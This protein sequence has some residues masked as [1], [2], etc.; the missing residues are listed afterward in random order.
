MPAVITLLLLSVFSPAFWG[1]METTS[2][3]DIQ[4]RNL[5]VQAFRVISG[6]DNRTPLSGV[7]V[8]VYD[9]N[10]ASPAATELTNR[11]GAANINLET[12][13]AG[14]NINVT[15]AYNNQVQSKTSIL[16]CR[17][18]LLVFLFD[19]TV[20]SNI[21]CAN[22]SGRD[23][24][25]FVNEN[26]SRELRQNMP[27]GIRRYER[28][29]SLTNSSQTESITV[30]IPAVNAPYDIEGV[31]IGSSPTGSNPV[32]VPPN[33]TLSIC[34]SA[35]TENAGIFNQSINL[36]LSCEGS[37]GT[38]TLDLS[39]EV[40]EPGCDCE[41]LEEE[42]IVIL[43][44]SVPV[45]GS[46]E[47]TEV[48]FTNTLSCA[49]EISR[50]GF[51]GNDGWTILSPQFPQTLQPGES[52]TIEA[53]FTPVK[54]LENSDTLNLNI[55]PEGTQ[56]NCPFDVIFSGE[57]CSNSCP[58]LAFDVYPLRIFNSPVPYDTLSNRDD[59]R[60][61]VSITDFDPP[62]LSTV[63]KAYTVYNPDSACNEITIDITAIPQDNYAGDY[64]SISPQR[65]TLAPGDSSAVNVIFTAPSYQELQQIAAAR[66]NTGQTS[67]SAFTIRLRLQ[68]GSCL[69]EV[70]ISSVV[71]I[72]PEISP[73]INLRAYSQRTPLKPEPEKEIYYLGDDARTINRGI[74][75][76]WGEY[77]PVNGDIY[78]DV[79]DTLASA[80]PP[81]EPILK[82]IDP[83]IEMKLWRTQVPEA[84]FSNVSAIVTEFSN[85]PGHSTGYSQNPITNLNVGDIIAFKI[86]AFT[87][88]L[89][90]IRRVDNGTE[91]T[92][93]R[94]SG[95]E[96]RTIYPI[97]IPF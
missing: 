41:E 89:M 23:S 28:C 1:C 44:E 26:G 11:N 68:A 42:Y 24:L 12:P 27:E 8:N 15:A 86:N 17:D 7:E 75:G 62:F 77:P 83:N 67:D 20:V 55:Q 40:V 59:N 82:L 74:N 43:P 72:F 78:I 90:Y 56:N 29:W 30:S 88:G 58:Y 6:G 35:G 34:F 18:T 93:S 79:N 19:T 51:D 37:Q 16:I 54:A 33:T 73:I 76:T 5:V 52:L 3:E 95:I 84:D 53:R 13:L 46:E 14:R 97:Y 70:N 81:Q 22:L 31:Y 49:V 60:V 25:I 61:F 47:H 65:I 39:A 57:G 64:Y 96:F 94:Q 48:V 80:Q 9:I 92:S 32:T 2:P 10:E 38:Y 85:D 36:G 4:V 69:Q 87:Y 71:T 66:G 63:S 21:D 50:T 91:S 45:G